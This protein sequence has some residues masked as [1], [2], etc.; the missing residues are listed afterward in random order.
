MEPWLNTVWPGPRSTSEPGGVFIHPAF[1]PFGHNKHEPKTGGL[2]PFKGGAATP[3]N[4]TLPQLRFTSVPSGILM[5]PAVWQQR[6]CAKNWVGA[7]PFFLGE[8]VPIEDNVA[9]AEAYLH[10]KWYLSPSSLLATFEGGAGSSLT[11]CLL[12]WGLPVFQ[13]V[14]WYIQPF[15]HNRHGPKIV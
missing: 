5:H 2:C 8:L 7:V 14:S 11:Q 9:W 12:G 1:Q 6:T 10:T 15:G 4:T 13:V 3:S